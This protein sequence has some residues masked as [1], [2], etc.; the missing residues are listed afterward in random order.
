MAITKT[1]RHELIEWVQIAFKEGYT[2]K[3]VKDG[4]KKFPRD[5]RLIV[6]REY[7]TLQRQEK[8]RLKRVGYDIKNINKLKGGLKKK[9]PKEKIDEEEDDDDDEVD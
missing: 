4:F 7:Q 6:L 9:M 3:Q 1:E 2:L 5:A 8:K